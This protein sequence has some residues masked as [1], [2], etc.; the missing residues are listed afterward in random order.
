M[1]AGGGKSVNC[2]RDAA[3]KGTLQKTKSAL[4]TDG[5]EERDAIYNSGVLPDLEREM[6]DFL[7]SNGIDVRKSQCVLYGEIDK[8]KL[9]ISTEMGTVPTL[10]NVRSGTLN[11]YDDRNNKFFV[12]IRLI[13][14]FDCTYGDFHNFLFSQIFNSKDPL[15]RTKETR[16]VT[17]YQKFE[18]F[19]LSLSRTIDMS[20]RSDIPMDYFPLYCLLVE[21]CR[22]RTD[23][24]LIPNPDPNLSRFIKGNRVDP[25][26]AKELVEQKT[27]LGPVQF[28]LDYI[29]NLM[30]DIEA[31]HSAFTFN[32]DALL[33]SI[34]ALKG[35]ISFKGVEQIFVRLIFERTL[36][37]VNPISIS[38]LN[39]FLE[40][41]DLVRFV[42]E[43]VGQKFER[44]L[45]Y[46]AVRVEIVRQ[47]STID[48]SKITP[49]RFA[50]IMKLIYEQV[51]ELS[52]VN[53]FISFISPSS[54]M[55]LS[56]MIVA[57]LLLNASQKSTKNMV[58]A[59]EIFVAHIP[60]CP[61][62]EKFI[63]DNKA[64][65]LDVDEFFRK[66]YVPITHKTTLEELVKR[67]WNCIWAIEPRD[68]YHVNEPGFA[69]QVY[70]MLFEM[71]YQDH[72]LIREFILCMAAKKFSSVKNMNQI[73]DPTIIFDKKCNSSYKRG[74]LFYKYCLELQKD[75]S[76]GCAKVSSGGCCSSEGS[77]RYIPLSQSHFQIR[78]IV[79]QIAQLAL[80]NECPICFEEMT[81]ETKSEFHPHLRNG[82]Q[83]AHCACNACYHS[84]DKCPT[85]RQAK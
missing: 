55:Y 12:L 50:S 80:E 14:S 71:F 16:S 20:I 1:S 33:M 82:T 52:G 63:S 3:V 29:V 77:I 72:P 26:C 39:Q 38:E 5:R 27:K 30:T 84:L 51:D 83:A 57:E 7:T 60:S 47:F 70:A 24:E 34:L 8:D 49:Q 19:V 10:E 66:R 18:F 17:E 79:Q 68:Y 58:L 46:W 37:N 25:V 81:S 31:G 54:H 73:F 78:E 75:C 85:C 69:K 76:D 48:I 23:E 53:S 6:I 43:K 35:F 13:P 59:T 28:F 61:L 67:A 15:N 2:V 56:D 64:K 36:K 41:D 11:H 22:F 32:L 42:H 45:K 65:K 4:P 9:R 62:L 44:K 21:L 74:F 40:M